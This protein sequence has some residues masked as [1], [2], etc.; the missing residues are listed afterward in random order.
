MDYQQKNPLKYYI[1]P[2][3]KMNTITT[4]ECHSRESGNPDTVPA[5]AGNYK[6]LDSCFHRKP[7]IPAY[8]GM[9]IDKQKA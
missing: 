3:N 7:W 9:T 6:E 1:H 2:Y 5:K 8:A 4:N